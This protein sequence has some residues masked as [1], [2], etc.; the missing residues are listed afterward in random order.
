LPPAWASVLRRCSSSERSTGR[1]QD[2]P[3][4]LATRGLVTLP[5]L[6]L[7]L[8]FALLSFLAADF[9]IRGLESRGSCTVQTRDIKRD[10]K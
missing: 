10:A 6:D 1:P 3:R 7:P 4:L 2:L 8:A 9:E 5:R